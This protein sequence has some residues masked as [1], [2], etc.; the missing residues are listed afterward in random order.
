MIQ[1]ALDPS[2]SYVA[3]SSSTKNVSLVDFESGDHIATLS[4]HA[5]SSL[6]SYFDFVRDKLPG[7]VAACECVCVYLYV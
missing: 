7:V 4:G 6:N 1:I 5:G 2:G 3:T